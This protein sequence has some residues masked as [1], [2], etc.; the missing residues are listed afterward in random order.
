MILVCLIAVESRV[1]R[2]FRMRGKCS[3]SNGISKYRSTFFRH[4]PAARSLARS[5]S[6]QLGE[7]DD[8]IRT[9]EPCR[10][11]IDAILAS[12]DERSLMKRRVFDDRSVQAKE[13]DDQKIER[14][15]LFD[16]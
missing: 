4:Q 5:I 12:G 14:K 11:Q 2:G 16:L 8:E 9:G 7:R 10:K 3:R 6:I 13:K 15:V 1:E